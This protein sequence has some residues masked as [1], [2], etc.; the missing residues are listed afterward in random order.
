MRCGRCRELII[1]EKVEATGTA[2]MSAV[3]E[4]LV[5][6]SS[7]R[8]VA[9]GLDDLIHDWQ[10]NRATEPPVG[11]A[12]RVLARI[13]APPAARQDWVGGLLWPALTAAASLVLFMLSYQLLVQTPVP[14]LE[15]YLL[16]GQTREEIVLAHAG[17]YE[18]EA[19]L[20]GEEQ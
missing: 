1:L 5:H 11:L 13:S 18:L 4:H 6:C 20:T 8:Q 19:Y 9:R 17:A 2:E 12:D 16:D 15:Y 14:T 7:C 10:R 3:F